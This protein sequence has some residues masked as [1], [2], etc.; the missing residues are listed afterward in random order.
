MME[1]LQDIAQRKCSHQRSR[2]ECC[3]HVYHE[4]QTTIYIYLHILKGNVRNEELHKRVAT[5]G[6]EH[7]GSIRNVMNLLFAQG[8]CTNCA[9][10]V[11]LHF[12][13]ALNF[14]SR[15]DLLFRSET[16]NT[17]RNSSL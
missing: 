13:S 1:S 6:A 2:L 7:R 4:E 5:F 11:R 9:I 15:T 17:K 12:L 16:P 8:M 10:P 3:V 14:P